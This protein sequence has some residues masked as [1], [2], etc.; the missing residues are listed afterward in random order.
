MR[1]NLEAI[2][3]GIEIEDEGV[4]G[5]RPN[6]WLSSPGVLS[7]VE[8][9]RAAEYAELE[10]TRGAAAQAAGGRLT[11]RPPRERRTTLD[12]S[13]RPAVSGPGY[14]VEVAVVAGQKYVRRYI[15]CGKKCNRCTPGGK[16]YDAD[17]PGHGPYWYRLRGN[18]NGTGP[19]AGTDRMQYIGTDLLMTHEQRDLIKAR[20]AETRRARVGKGLGGPEHG[21]EHSTP[22]GGPQTDLRGSGRGP[23]PDAGRSPHGG[24][25]GPAGSVED[26]GGRDVGND[27]NGGGVDTGG[28]I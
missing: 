8:A 28:G 18:I 4:A 20:R 14:D 19:R 15:K 9:Q 26:R 2:L 21:K 3:D 27:S 7:A 1:H 10:A 6:P 11:K 24:R 5:P 22:E 12:N 23:D 16:H 17:R 13:L 25:T